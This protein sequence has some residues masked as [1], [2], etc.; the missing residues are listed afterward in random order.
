MKLANLKKVLLNSLRWSEKY[1]KTDM[2]Y[3]AR[4]GFWLILAKIVLSAISFVTMLAF[5]N[6]WTGE[7]GKIAY[8][9]YQFIIS[10]LALLVIF[11]LPEINT[12]IVKSIA[13][14][15][16]GTL[17][18][19]V[20]ERIRWGLIGSFLCLGLVGYY[21]L[22]GNNLLAWAFLL[23]AIFVP[24][25]TTFYIFPAFWTGRKRF[26]LRA[27][28]QIASAGLA[29]IFLISAIYLTNNVLIIIAVFLASHT[30]FDWFFYKKTLKQAI[31]DEKDESCISFGKN[32]TVMSAVQTAAVYLDRIIIW[33]FLGAVS[34]A[35]YSFAKQPIDKIRDA[36]PIAPLALPK[37][38]ERKIDEQ[39]KK[40]VLLKF[41]KLFAV[42]IPAALLLALM[43]DPLYKLLFPQY[44]DS[45]IYF[46]VLSATVAISPF[47]LLIAALTAE[48]KKKAL[49]FVN[50]GAPV[51]KIILFLA[52]I[53]NFGLWGIVAAI[54]IAEVIRG[55]MALYFFLRM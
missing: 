29:T 24:F 20:K 25:K 15:K 30:F 2:V 17:S 54:L 49:Y 14:K 7:E 11:A 19:A 43:A 36:L 35:V 45:I 33:Y 4:G 41:I 5:A 6:W 18:L 1:T 16:E 52:L 50:T 3:V 23:V 28:Y 32:L 34:V 55:F 12:A 40:S 27:K 39:R 53:P 46:Q 51:L 13:Q 48:M 31:N 22:Q 47:L 10:G 44:T 9:T 42:T 8:G 37:L 38:G 21:F 26:D